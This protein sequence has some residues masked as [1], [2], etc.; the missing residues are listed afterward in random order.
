[1]GLQ[2]RE[3][4]ARRP[5]AYLG[6]RTAAAKARRAAWKDP[7]WPMTRPPRP[8]RRPWRSSPCARGGSPATASAGRWAIRASGWRW[9]RPISSNAATA[10]AASCSPRGRRDLKAS[11]WRPGSTKG[12]AATEAGRA[13]RDLGSDA[14]DAGPRLAVLQRQPGKRAR[15]SGLL[16]VGQRDAARIDPQ[17]ALEGMNL[18]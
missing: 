3:L 15:F 16:A 7:P 6:A 17:R 8:R 13:P 14:N 10:T 4:T 9:A 12:R 5:L 2:G 11:A 18:G 1:M